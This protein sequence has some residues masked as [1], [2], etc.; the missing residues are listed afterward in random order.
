M[1]FE[2]NVE[3]LDRHGLHGWAY[4]RDD[5]APVEL[6][7]HVADRAPVRLLANFYRSDLEQAGIGDGRH[8]FSLALEGLSPLVPHTVRVARASDGRDV[9]GSPRVVEASL[10]I[11][12]GLQDHLA[13][14][15]AGTEGEDVQ[16]HW[17]A[18][19]AQQADRLLQ[20][21]A[22][23]RS[24]R[25][26]AS[27]PQMFRVR[28]SGRDAPRPMPAPRAL[29]IDDRL[30]REDRD[31]GSRAVMSHVRSLQ[32]LGYAV[33]FAAADMVGDRAGGDGLAALEAAGVACHCAPWCGSVEEV[34]R[35]EADSFAVAYIH[36]SG[37]ARYLPLV[38]HHQRR[39]RVVLS[40]ADLQHLRLARQA[41]AEGRPELLDLSRRVRVGELSAASAADRVITHST[42][43]AALLRQALPNARVHV[44]PWAVTPC[45][46][47]T[48]F[49]ERHGVA[50]IGSYPHPPNLD[51]AWWLL[52]DVMPLVR[53][54]HPSITCTLAGSDMPDSLRVA[55][56]P[57]VVM[58]GHVPELASLFGRVRLT[59]APLTFGAGVKG[60]V[61]DSLAHG[62]PCA[63]TPV[64]AEG[65]GLPPALDATVAETAA[66]LAQVICRL[67]EDAAFNGACREAGLGYVRERLA[68]AAVDAA[69]REVVAA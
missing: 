64:A 25:P 11:D 66:G 13:R 18:F 35:R 31:A 37:N 17:A 54:R 23:H 65:I 28:W 1:A 34:L 58:L 15:L 39:A 59:A 6:V 24:R 56:G 29:V 52:Q 51:A 22:D 19:L 62:V 12:A 63:C 16:R 46:A 40:V 53:E 45:P 2:G 33:T 10:Q 21:A 55:A 60:K 36:R 41:E 38:R 5:P 57:G 9:P 30:P 27:A 14:L 44:V 47:P 8:G 68:E 67:H 61:L 3:V 26:P 32:R 7:V 4:D 50:F 42:Y 20:R 48:P 69:M 49:E 43:E